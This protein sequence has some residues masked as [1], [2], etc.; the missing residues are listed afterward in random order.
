M[1][2]LFKTFVCHNAMYKLRAHCRNMGKR[3]VIFAHMPML[4]CTLLWKRREIKTTGQIIVE[5][6]HRFQFA[7]FFTQKIQ[8]VSPESGR[9]HE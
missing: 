5:K 2:I 1:S 6:E 8:Q 4:P 7:L 9:G 3:T